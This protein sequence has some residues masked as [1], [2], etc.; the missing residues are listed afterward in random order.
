MTSYDTI[1]GFD[2]KKKDPLTPLNSRLTVGKIAIFTD[3][4]RKKPIFT[5]HG[6][7]F[8]KMMD[9]RR[10]VYL[11]SMLPCANKETREMVENIT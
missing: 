8:G 6:K 7:E 5:D 4:G 9:S 11:D 3:H 2:A 10:L 1:F